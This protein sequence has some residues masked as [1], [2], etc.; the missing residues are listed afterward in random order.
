MTGRMPYRMPWMTYYWGTPINCNGSIC[1]HIRISDGTLSEVN[2]EKGIYWYCS[3]HVDHVLSSG[4]CVV[5]LCQPISLFRSHFWGNWIRVDLYARPILLDRSTCN[6]YKIKIHNNLNCRSG[7]CCFDV[8]WELGPG[9]SRRCGYG[10]D[11]TTSRRV[12]YALLGR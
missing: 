12:F 7:I 5:G 2:D 10:I 6:L 9:I 8:F 1:Q 4:E 11:N 3:F